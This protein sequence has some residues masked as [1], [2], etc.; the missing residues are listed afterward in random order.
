MKLRLIEPL[1]DLHESNLFPEIRLNL[2]RFSGT[3]FVINLQITA[4]TMAVIGV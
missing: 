1:G 2:S 3:I 4:P